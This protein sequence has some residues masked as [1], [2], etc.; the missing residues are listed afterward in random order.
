MVATDNIAEMSS[1]GW[2]GLSPDSRKAVETLRLPVLP[3]VEGPRRGGRH[4]R[5][6]AENTQG[7]GLGAALPRYVGLCGACVGP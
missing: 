6:K 1:R 2:K 5:N 4:Y 7:R 3:G